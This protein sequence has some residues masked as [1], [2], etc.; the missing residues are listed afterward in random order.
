MN[1]CRL[2]FVNASNNLSFKNIHLFIII[3]LFW[4]F[5]HLSQLLFCW[6]STCCGCCWWGWDFCPPCFAVVLLHLHLH[7][8]HL[9]VSSS[10]SETSCPIVSGSC[11][12]SKSKLIPSSALLDSNQIQIFVNMI[13]G[14]LTCPS[15]VWSPGHVL[16]KEPK[17]L[18]PVIVIVEDCDFPVIYFC[19]RPCKK[20]NTFHPSFHKIMPYRWLVLLKV[21]YAKI[22]GT[23]TEQGKI[24][25]K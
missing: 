21:F 25:T 18:A 5:Q 20:S 12:H 10:R 13:I 19:T 3:F 6:S 8:L 1:F 4:D 11:N 17:P 2:Q 9:A 14:Q 7:L 16:A 22:V 23:G 24:C 15:P